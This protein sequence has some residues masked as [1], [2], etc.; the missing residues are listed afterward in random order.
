MY[1]RM[2]FETMIT[3]SPLAPDITLLFQ[4][5]CQDLSQGQ[6]CPLSTLVHL[7]RLLK[8]ADYQKYS[9]LKKAW[10][11]FIWSEQ[12]KLEYVRVA[13]CVSV[14]VVMCFR[15]KCFNLLFR[16]SLPSLQ[17]WVVHVANLKWD[18]RCQLTP[19]FSKCGL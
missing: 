1:Q 10:I 5:L 3:L 15:S 12:F 2:A 17:F 13:V 16:C 18:Y 8:K 7:Y 14:C 6:P 19:C 9:H 4:I 11:F